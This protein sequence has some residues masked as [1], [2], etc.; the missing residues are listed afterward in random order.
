MLGLFG[1]GKPDHPLGDPKEA[2]RLIDEL[3]AQ[4]ALKALEELA[5]WHESVSA[6]QGFRPDA[7]I[8]ALFLLDEAAQPRVRKVAREYLAAARPSRF[9]ENRLWTHVYEYWRQA[10][11]AYAR[12]IDAVLQNAKGSDLAKPLLPLAVTRALRAIGQQ[13]KWLHLRYAP[14]DA[15]VWQV[16]HG[17]YA[18]AELRGIADAPVPSVHPGVPGESSPRLEYL[19][20]LALNASS[21]DSL[22]PVQVE[23]AERLIAELASSFALG[24]QPMAGATHWVD[25]GQGMAPQRLVKPPQPGVGV[26]YLASGAALQSLQA[27]LARIEATSVLPDAFGPGAPIT[28]GEGALD[29][30][31]HLI[32]YWA[33]AA[34]E[35]KHPR[36]NV[37]SRLSIVHGFDGVVAALLAGGA[38]SQLDFGLQPPE[39]WIVENVSAGGFGA[40]VQQAKADWLKIGALLAMQPDGGNNWI[41]GIVRR[42][43]R[44]AAQEARVGIQTLSRAPE[45]ARFGLR[46]KEEIGVLLPAP[47]LG[48]GEASIAM[49]AGVFV[50]GL[51]LET[52]RAGRHY[53]YMPQGIAERGEDYDIIRFREMVRES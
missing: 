18:F 40:I 23:A 1:S 3:P 52:A 29:L 53:M 43:S 19:R 27:M 41:V 6:A 12:A 30:L 39:S 34:P 5:H 49:H 17:V 51:N 25:L 9:Q 37:K 21:P 16:L 45:A 48:S 44:N 7:R 24:A 2:K 22:L 32:L 46:G 50:A 4:D 20:A 28:D 33:P 13:V 11:Q 26:R 38:E 14:V 31:R 15:A 36:H 47:G 8:Q 10:A 42:V 35:R